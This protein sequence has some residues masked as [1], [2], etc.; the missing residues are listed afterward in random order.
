MAVLGLR[1]RQVVLPKVVILK[2]SS[3]FVSMVALV[4][5]MPRRS[6]TKFIQYLKETVEY[7]HSH[8]SDGLYECGAT[9]GHLDILRY[10]VGV[11]VHVALKW[12]NTYMDSVIIGILRVIQLTYALKSYFRWSN[13]ERWPSSSL[14]HTEHAQDG[15]WLPY[16]TVFVFSSTTN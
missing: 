12:S 10:P 5:F 2:L 13:K 6:H 9:H 11:M 3:I 7:L 14:T 15:L 4:T 16:P 1:I 8:G